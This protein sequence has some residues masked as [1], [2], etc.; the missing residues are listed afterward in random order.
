MKPILNS[1]IWAAVSY[2]PPFFALLL[3]FKGRDS[4]VFFHARQAIW[5]WLLFVLALII[6]LLPGQFFALVKWP[7]SITAAMLFIYLFINGI[8]DALQGK[9]NPLPPFGEYIQRKGFFQSL[10]K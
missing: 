4:L 3:F 2:L 8:I 1:K 6:I 7:I 5:I 9:A 10:H